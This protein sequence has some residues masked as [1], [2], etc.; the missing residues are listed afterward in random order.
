MEHNAAA[1]TYPTELIYAHNYDGIYRVLPCIEQD[2]HYQETFD[3]KV[4]VRM[5]AMRFSHRESSA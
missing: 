2:A 5:L 4:Q 3:A 1:L